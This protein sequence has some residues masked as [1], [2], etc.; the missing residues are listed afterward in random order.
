M[1]RL[2]VE[3][4]NMYTTLKMMHAVDLYSE[5][6]FSLR[7]LVKLH[8]LIKNKFG[9]W[10]MTPYSLMEVYRRSDDI[11]CHHHLVSD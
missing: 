11:Y 8:T 5:I 3:R 4:V 7:V 10:A 1:G 6:N 2:D 9:F